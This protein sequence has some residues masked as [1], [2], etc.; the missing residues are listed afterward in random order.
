MWC[1]GNWTTTCENMKSEHYHH[2]WGFLRGSDGKEAACKTG[3]PAS[4]LGSG[5]SPREE[6]GNPCQ[7][8]CLENSME[9]GTWWAIVLGVAKSQT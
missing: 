4:I 3:E 8:S 1:W 7:Y 6:N 5:R 2:T 9:R